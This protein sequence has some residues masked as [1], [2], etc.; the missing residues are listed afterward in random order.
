MV[1][2]I[3]V[4]IILNLNTNKRKL[5]YGSCGIFIQNEFTSIC[6][7]FPNTILR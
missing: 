7:D 5:S 2:E 6:A 1:N 3:L 4:F